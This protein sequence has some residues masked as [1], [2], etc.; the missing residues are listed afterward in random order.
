[1]T[2]LKSKL[3]KVHL[4]EELGKQGFY[5]DTKK[6]VQIFTETVQKNK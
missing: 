2:T 5:Y 3:K 6:P 4:E 1:M